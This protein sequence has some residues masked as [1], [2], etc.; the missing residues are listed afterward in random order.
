MLNNNIFPQKGL[1]IFLFHG[2]IKK[3]TNEIRNYKKKHL[4]VSFFE[5]FIRHVQTNGIPLSMDEVVEHYKE[6]KSFSPNSFAVTFDDGFENNYSIAAPILRKYEIPATFYITT[7]FVNKNHMSW[8]DRIEYCFEKTSKA[9][10]VLPWDSKTY[11]FE[12]NQEKIKILEMIRDNVKTNPLID[13]EELVASI[14]TQCNQKI[15]NQSNDPLDLKMNWN[16]IKE[17]NDNE[18]FIIGGHSH[19]HSI[20]SFLDSCSLD[21]EVKKSVFLLK[22]KADIRIKH[23]SYPE[24]LKHCYSNEVIRTLKKYG[25]ICCPTAEDG[26][27][28]IK[29]NLFYLKRKNVI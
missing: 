19:T 23:Y 28:D 22:N 6:N 4:E 8:I 29:E 26:V 2:V 17:L 15:I 9:Y 11:Q 3:Q 20:L 25:I 1:V 21:S 13:F 24:G 18:N 7:D 10:L 16:Q 5:N 12:N 14:F 27:N